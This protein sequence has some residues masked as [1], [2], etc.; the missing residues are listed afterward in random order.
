MRSLITDE[1]EA[2]LKGWV[3]GHQNAA[4]RVHPERWLKPRYQHLRPWL[5][6][7]HQLPQRLSN[8][9][10][11]GVRG[12][13]SA[14]QLFFWA[15]AWGFGGVGQGYGAWRTDQMLGPTDTP[16]RVERLLGFV[17]KGKVRQ[18]FAALHDADSCRLPRL[19]TSFGTKL[20]Y[21]GGFGL[22]AGTWEPLVLDAMVV[23]AFAVHELL[24]PAGAQAFACVQATTSDATIYE[25]YLRGM[26]DIRD[27][28]SPET[29]VD[30]IERWVW[31][32]G[33]GEEVL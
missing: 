13:G 10:V 33:A 1:A 25:R 11:L 8:D 24:T 29:R 17:A 31:S 26:H 21:F 23:R 4:F 19:G 18:A 20:L 30:V 7:L 15:M 6:L 14:M 28:H 12:A 2:Q 9:D 32:I 27:E 5:P 3:S 16:Q 22:S